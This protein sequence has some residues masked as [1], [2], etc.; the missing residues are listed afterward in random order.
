MGSVAL[1]SCML[2]LMAMMTAAWPA[3]AQRAG[4]YQVK[5]AYLY[6]FLNFVEWPETAF[7]GQGAPFEICVFGTDP[8]GPDLDH[9]IDNKQV[10]GRS[11]RV[12][13]SAGASPPGGCHI[14]FIAESER[15]RVH[16][17]LES[18]AKQP[19]LTVGELPGFEESGGMV[20]FIVHSDIVR[21]RINS[22]PAA[23]AGLK[24]SS[25]LLSVATVVGQPVR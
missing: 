10:R 14:L 11:I 16:W 18:V 9:V 3:A 19:T 17:V 12:R 21:L 6:H 23:E 20:R 8:F 15:T 5:A 25:R 1:R 22:R 7:Q 13:R 24:I 4:E 2:A